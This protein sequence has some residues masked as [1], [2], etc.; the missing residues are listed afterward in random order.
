MRSCGGRRLQ[1]ENCK[2]QIGGNGARE[3]LQVPLYF[4]HAVVNDVAVF[5]GGML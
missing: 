1:S 3:W 2:L 4:S 5:F